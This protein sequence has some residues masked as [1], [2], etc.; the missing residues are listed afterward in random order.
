MYKMI[1]LLIHNFTCPF[2]CVYTEING[3]GTEDILINVGIAH[4]VA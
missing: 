1:V 3:V 4:I 2:I